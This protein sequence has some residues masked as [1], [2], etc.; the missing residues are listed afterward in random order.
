MAFCPYFSAETKS[1]YTCRHVDNRS[2]P[3]IK[4]IV[5]IRLYF[6]RTIQICSFGS[7][8]RS[9]KTGVI[10]NNE[11][12]DFSVPDRNSSSG[13]LPVVANFI[14]PGTNGAHPL[15]PSSHRRWIHEKIFMHSFPMGRGNVDDAVMYQPTKYFHTQITYSVYLYIAV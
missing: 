13:F 5:I 14:E 4:L 9:R 7:L 15:A 6:S 12:D 11:M 1:Y 3:Q 8:V 2:I 10:F